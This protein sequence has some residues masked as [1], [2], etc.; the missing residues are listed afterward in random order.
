MRS[1][2][3]SIMVYRVITMA[4][5]VPHALD[6]SPWHAIMLLKK[7]VVELFGK[8]ANLKNVK[9]DDFESVLVFI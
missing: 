6:L 5:F 2:P 7:T 4:D 9:G 3:D 8:F 1:V